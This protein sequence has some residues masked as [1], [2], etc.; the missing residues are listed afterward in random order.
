VLS[1]PAHYI[2]CYKNA[3]WNQFRHLLDESTNLNGLSASIFQT[4]EEID[5]AIDHLITQI[6]RADSVAVPRAQPNRFRML[7]SDELRDQIQIRN[8]RRRTARDTNDSTLKL[9][10]KT[11]TKRIQKEVNSFHSESWN[12]KLQTFHTTDNKFWKLSKLIKNRGKTIPTLKQDGHILTTEEE[13]VNAIADCFK[14]AHNLTVGQISPHEGEV[15]SYIRGLASERFLNEDPSTYTKPSEI[16]AILRV[17]K[18]GKAPGLDGINNRHLKN[19]PRKV[20]VYLTHIF[21][22]CIRLGYFP[23]QWKHAKVVA[24]PKPNK[25]A[26]NPNNYRPISLLSAVG[27]LFERIILKRLNDH[28][29][30]NNIVPLEQFGF[31]TGL[32]TTHQ[33]YRIVD[34]IRQNL[35][36]GRS[37]GMVFFDAEKAFDSVWHGGLLFKLHNLHYPRYLQHLSSSFLTERSFQVCINKSFSTTINIPAGVPQGSVLSPSLYNIFNHDIPKHNETESAFYADDTAIFS[38]NTYPLFV[39]DALQEHTNSLIKYFDDW[40]I[41]I[42][43]SK[44]EAIYFTRRRASRFLPDTH[45]NVNGLSVPWTT[46]VKYLGLILDKKLIF[47]NHVEH[48]LDKSS[49]LIKIYYPFINRRSR[50]NKTVKL[51]LF[52][53]VFR[54]SM[55][56]ASPVW[57][58]CAASHRRRLQVM[59]NKI[60]KMIL[61][62]PWWHS[63]DDLHDEAD[64]KT[65]VDHA[66]L[67]RQGFVGSLRF[68][69]NP[70]ISGLSGTLP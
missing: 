38:S 67:V 52:K 39:T 48:I 2:P 25:D 40:K 29:A 53:T 51:T 61:R 4:P 31:S 5:V 8:N 12:S 16:S 20:I 36:I 32:S 6:T 1:V 63:T 64:M 68:S 59:Q 14:N 7:L 60:L 69:Q 47:K 28:T 33:L 18:N 50:L 44:T 21:N 19:L 42:N 34:K 58:G 56:Y 54:A 66:G 10:A 70:L 35:D 45:I 30:Q 65:I 62:K 37:T 57:A 15:N 11:L 24:I 22:N 27:K 9:V 23:K 43:S 13:K 17:L 49:K 3:N 41:K 55:L 46:K 26:T